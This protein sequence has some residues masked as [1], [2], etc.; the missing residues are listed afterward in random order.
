VLR[1]AV[2]GRTVTLVLA[3]VAVA[4][5]G[6]VPVLDTM[7]AAELSLGTASNRAAQARGLAP[8][9]RWTE[10]LRVRNI[11]S[12][13]L[14]YRLRFVTRGQLWHCDPGPSNLNY[15]VVWGED[16]D[17]R[18]E[19]GEIESA[20]IVLNFPLVVGNECQGHSGS[21]LVYR[22]LAQAARRGGSQECCHVSFVPRG[23]KRRNEHSPS[24]GL[25]FRDLLQAEQVLVDSDVPK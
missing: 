19:R 7:A 10:V 1:L 20:T 17:W 24:D 4:Y 14:T 16:V 8:G 22:G 15:Q 6:T 23:S 5:L 3:V 13:T 11:C 18:L 21:L 9:D 25:H 12:E 2:G